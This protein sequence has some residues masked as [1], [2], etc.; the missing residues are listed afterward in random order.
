[1][2][3]LEDRLIKQLD[4][5]YRSE[6]KQ[7]LLILNKYRE[8]NNGCIWESDWTT[9]TIGF[10][11][12]GFAELMYKPSEVGK[13]FLKGVEKINDGCGW[14]LDEDIDAYSTKCGHAFIFIEGGPVANGFKYCPYCG[15]DIQG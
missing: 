9:L 8:L 5:V 12:A 15:Q 2:G 7:C 13:I 1:M 14:T 11:K 10:N 6:A 3:K 4:T